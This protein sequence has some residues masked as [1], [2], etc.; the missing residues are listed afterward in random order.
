MG[1]TEIPTAQISATNPALPQ[2]DPS[3]LATFRELLD[4]RVHLRN[5]GWGQ[6]TWTDRLAV[7]GTAAAPVVA[8]GAIEACALCDS[9]E[10]WRSYFTVGETPLGAAHVEG[11][12]SLSA[13]TAYHVYVWVDATA[14]AGPK[15]QISATPPIEVATPAEVRAWKRTLLSNYRFLGSFVTDGSGNPLPMLT[16]RG[17]SLLRRSAVATVDGD[18]VTVGASFACGGLRALFRNTPNATKTD[19]GLALRVPP[20]A[21]SVILRLTA[22]T[23]SPSDSYAELNLYTDADT[24]SPAAT[25]S[26][27]ADSQARLDVE[28]PLAP[29]SRVVKY[30][31]ARTG[32]GVG[33]VEAF[34]DLLGWGL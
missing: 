12:G 27:Q 17:R 2:G 18:G 25:L 10:V 30:T 14:P 31:L 20:T 34:V 7:S 29:G 11:G 16:A 6:I 22:T 28:I 5:V 1:A 21:R 8:V 4:N 3:N 23:S 19:L 24:T 26:T 13:S 33:A 9:N 15:F 32:A